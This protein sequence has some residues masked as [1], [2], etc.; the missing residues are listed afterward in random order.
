MR[1]GTLGND[2]GLVFPSGTGAPLSGGNLNCA[3]K[4]F[5]KRARFSSVTRFH[6][7]LHTCATLL[8]RQGVNP[9]FVQELLGHG[10]VG[11]PSIAMATTCQTRAPLPLAR[12]TTPWI[13]SRWCSGCCRN[14]SVEVVSTL[15]SPLNG[16]P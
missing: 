6:E 2:H 10:D 16:G 11:L 7:L 8:L 4:A 3:F 9:K 12:W 14:A 15:W 5:L 13:R 1:L